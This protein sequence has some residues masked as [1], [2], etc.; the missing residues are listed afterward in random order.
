MIVTYAKT[1]H[2]KKI[3]SRYLIVNISFINLDM[4]TKN[5]FNEEEEKYLT[6]C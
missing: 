2:G 4:R 6:N 3:L 5:M 1:G